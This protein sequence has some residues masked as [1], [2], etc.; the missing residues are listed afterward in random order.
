[1]VAAIE[2]IL[3]EIEAY[4]ALLTPLDPADDAAAAARNAKAEKDFADRMADLALKLN[5]AWLNLQGNAQQNQQQIDPM[6]LQIMNSK[7]GGP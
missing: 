7:F 6:L 5:E 1:M 4:K 2:R 3:G